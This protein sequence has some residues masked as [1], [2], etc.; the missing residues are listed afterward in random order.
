M[1]I[2]WLGTVS[3]RGL[4]NVILTPRCVVAVSSPPAAL[5]A[6]KEQT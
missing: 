6:R 3:K 2:K 1:T 5:Y 4:R